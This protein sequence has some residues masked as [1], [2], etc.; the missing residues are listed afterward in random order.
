MESTGYVHIYVRTCALADRLHARRRFGAYGE[1]V[2]TD[3]RFQNGSRSVTD[4]VWK[5][6]G[7]LGPKHLASSALDPGCQIGWQDSSAFGKK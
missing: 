1:Q 4:E 2:R 7:Y 3:R 5:S 6:N